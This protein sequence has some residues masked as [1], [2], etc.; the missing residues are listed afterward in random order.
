MLCRGRQAIIDVV[1]GL[2][3]LHQNRIAHLDMKTSNILIDEHGRC[4]ISDLGMS[5]LLNREET[6]VPTANRDHG[7]YAYLPPEQFDGKWGFASDI[8]SLSTIIWEVNSHLQLWS[9]CQYFSLEAVLREVSN[10]FYI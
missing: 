4:K 7:T 8:W 10:S 5:K 9:C 6:N 3:V 2:Y 1:R